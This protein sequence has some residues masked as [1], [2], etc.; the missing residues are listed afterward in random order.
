MVY[1][2]VRWWSTCLSVRE[3]GRGLISGVIGEGSEVCLRL[4]GNLLVVGFVI[5][6]LRYPAAIPRSHF[7]YFF[8]FDARVPDLALKPSTGSS[9]GGAS[10]RPRF[11]TPLQLRLCV[12][13]WRAASSPR[14]TSSL[15]ARSSCRH[16]ERPPDLVASPRSGTSRVDQLSARRAH[17]AAI[18]ALVQINWTINWKL[19]FQP[20]GDQC[21]HETWCE[22]DPLIKK[23]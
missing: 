10:F 20:A 15:Q 23:S 4:P 14:N 16:T 1:T 12:Q 8:G 11:H 19:I 21:T 13:I 3:K 7:V 6:R 18:P 2:M 5:E 22:L 17:P 9:S